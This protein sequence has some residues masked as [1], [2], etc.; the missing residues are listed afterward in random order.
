MAPFKDNQTNQQ[1]NACE[2]DRKVRLQFTKHVE[3]L[4]S[5]KSNK[6]SKTK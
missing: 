4:T 2:A 6:Q 5:L 1:R 3:E